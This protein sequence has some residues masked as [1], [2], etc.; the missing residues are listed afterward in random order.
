MFQNIMVLFNFCYFF[1]FFLGVLV[2]VMG[3]YFFVKGLL[4]SIF[5]VYVGV[6]LWVLGL[7]GLGV[8]FLVML[9]ILMKMFGVVQMNLFKIF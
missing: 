5:V 1:I 8:L 9:M 3:V 6:E 2:G 7:V 4:D